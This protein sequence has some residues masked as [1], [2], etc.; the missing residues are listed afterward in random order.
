MAGKTSITR[1][2]RTDIPA[3]RVS[4]FLYG[5]ILVLSALVV[6]PPEALQTTRGFVYVLGVAFSTFVAHV[7]SDLFAHL[8]R[9]PDG[10]GLAA[11]LPGDLRDAVPIASSAMPATV[12]LVAAWLGWIQADL[13]WAIAIGVTLVPLS[14]LGPIA[15][16]IAREPFSLW[17]L[18]AGVLLALLIGVIAL[19]KAVLTH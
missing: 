7:M 3:R 9:H 17:P 15:A 8:L 2:P 12:V 1:E 14:L 5:N 6:L 18:S 4:A 11:K 19:L 10:E 16:W 13:A